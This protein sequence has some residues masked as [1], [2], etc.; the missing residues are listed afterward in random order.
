MTTLV[1]YEAA[2]YALK[3]AQQVD[4]VKDIRDKAQALAAYARQAKDEDMIRWATEIK[5]RAERRAGELLNGTERNKGAANA[6]TSGH[7]VVPTLD[8]IGISRK[9]SSDFQA[10]AAISEE[11]FEEKLKTEKP[12]TKSLVRESPRH[13]EKQTKAVKA[14]PKKPT[15]SDDKLAAAYA[16]LKGHCDELTDELK[17]V[18]AL[19]GT[20]AAVTMQKLREELRVCKRRRDELMAA[21]HE[22]AKQCKWW[23]HEAEKLGWKPK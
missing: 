15:A 5:L 21:N 18:Q 8:E 19:T 10:I 2:R 22:C 13:K 14:K 17:T 12:T 16:E 3:V 7:S 4:E 23:K 11:T 6:V 9:Q 20:D 1:R